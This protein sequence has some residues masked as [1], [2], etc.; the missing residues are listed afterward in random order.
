MSA[1]ITRVSPGSAEPRR[2]TAGGGQ[3]ADHYVYEWILKAMNL[4]EQAETAAPGP[5]Q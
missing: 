5:G 4:F 1:L 3:G 2:V